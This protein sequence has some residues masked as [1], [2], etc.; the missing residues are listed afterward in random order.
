[1]W[2]LMGWDNAATMASDVDAPSATYPRAIFG[3]L[4]LVVLTYVLPVACMG[5]AGVPTGGWTTGAWVDAAR[6]FGGLPLALAMAMA[7]ALS[8][9]GMFNALVLSYSRLPE[10]LS[11][12]GLLHPALSWRHPATKAP[13]RAIVLCAV[14]YT[15]CLT[16]GFERLVAL[17]VVFYGASLILEFIAL[18]VLRVREPQLRR[19]FRIPG[20]VATL[21]A[22]AL[23]PSL[24]LLFAVAAAWKADQDGR[25]FVLTALVGMAGPL[26]YGWASR[27]LPRAIDA[28]ETDG[29]R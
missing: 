11:A 5:I 21:V 8:A 20:G 13:V 17:D 18:L 7:G 25:G 12:D 6:L 9:I 16:L 2:N 1:M 26:L 10:A 28:D 22:V 15:A 19:P 27:R 24:L 23:P 29:S 3:A 4:A 14:A